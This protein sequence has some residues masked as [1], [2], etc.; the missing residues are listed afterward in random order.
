MAID[1]FCLEHNA[2]Q[3]RSM[4]KIKQTIDDAKAS[5]EEDA[6]RVLRNLQRAAQDIH[7]LFREEIQRILKPCFQQALAIKGMYV[8]LDYLISRLTTFVAGRGCVKQRNELMK[9]FADEHSADMAVKACE[10]VEAAL[11]ELIQQHAKKLE[12]LAADSIPGLQKQIKGLLGVSKRPLSSA[13][14]MNQERL[15]KELRPHLRSW[16]LCW[17][18]PSSQ[19]E[20]HVVRGELS[21]PE[22]DLIKVKTDEHGD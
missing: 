1:N 15:M 19:R 8:C 5:L 10:A 6:H 11:A 18:K 12:K 7:P 9:K 17:Q 20:D 16:E 22:P 13:A 4:E 2:M 3:P 21:I 14:R